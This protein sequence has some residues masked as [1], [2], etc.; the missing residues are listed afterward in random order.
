MTHEVIPSIRKH[1]AYAT[2]ATID[3]IM[4]DPDYGIRLLTALKEE[5]EKNALLQHKADYFDALVDRNL[6]TGIR[7]TAK[8]LH[9]KQKKLVTF[10]IEK[11]YVYRDHK[12]KLQP[13][14]E[15][16]DAGLFELKEC[17]SDRSEWT[18]TQLMVTPKGRETFRML[19]AMPAAS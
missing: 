16:V 5:R 6:L 7:E 11:G 18:G 13:Y 9:M 14:A 4:D 17:K 2:P 19:T 3:R 15:H 10:L 1:G 8:E 12:N